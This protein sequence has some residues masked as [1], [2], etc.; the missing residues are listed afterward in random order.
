M[1]I[2]WKGA[3]PNNYMV[4]RSGQKIEFIVCH[5][6][7]GTLESAGATFANASRLASATYG[8]GGKAVHQYVRDEDTAYANGNWQSNLKSLS[9]E[10]EGGP[11][12]PITDA[13]Y[14]TSAQLI[15][16]KAKL[17]NIPLDRQHIRKHNE[18]SD[19]P[20]QCP[21]T[22]DLDRL[23][24]RAKEINTPETPPPPLITDQTIIPQLGNMEVQAI[25]SQ[26]SDMKRD[27]KSYEE[28]SVAL[29]H[30]AEKVKEDFEV[31]KEQQK[32][33]DKEQV[34]EIG[35]RME[36][37]KDLKD[38]LKFYQGN[39]PLSEPSFTIAGYNVYFIKNG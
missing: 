9:I 12:I 29:I 3:H 19:K 20:T 35:R 34:S 26:I 30:D 25:R 36:E 21:G 24:K 33:K 27:L 16:E 31:Y 6:I 15:A 17:Y 14:E 28:N 38:R 7:V 37:I 23:I 2:T 1:T 18:V 13:T 22:L 5:W 8:V 11:S 32:E 4:G 39:T 10:H